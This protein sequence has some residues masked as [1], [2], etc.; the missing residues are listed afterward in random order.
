MTRR[1]LIFIGASLF[2]AVGIAQ[3]SMAQTST[4]TEQQGLRETSDAGILA[5]GA[6][7]WANQCSRCHNL[8]SPSE[9]SP[10][11]WDISV[12][13]MRVR[14]N[15]PGRTADDIKAFLMSS[16]KPGPSAS[17]VN[18]TAASKSFSHLKA[19]DKINGFEVYT[20]TCVACHGDNGKGALEGVPDFTLA[21]SRLH[22]PRETLMTNMI[23]GFQSDGSL[24]AMPPMG[25]N[26]DL[27]EQDMAD[28]LAYLITEFQSSD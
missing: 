21:N 6:E 15:I 16:T 5:R 20:Q 9:L 3:P 22:Q 12:M 10:D 25:G 2:A 4:E 11:L 14:A 17:V 23:S 27:T 24:M 8:R 13:H 28:V 19:G 7:A 1:T 26:P 18:Q